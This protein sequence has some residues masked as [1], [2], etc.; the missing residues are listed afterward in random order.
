MTPA[1]RLILAALISFL[2]A[3]VTGWWVIPL[4]RRLKAGQ[5]IRSDGPRHH[6]TKA[7]TPTMGGIIFALPAAVAALALTPR[8]GGGRDLVPMLVALGTALGHGAVGFADDYIKVVFRRPLGL[9]AREKLFF[10][11][12]LA[13]AL[14]WAAVRLLGL[15]TWVWVPFVNRTFDLGVLYYPFVLFL[16]L[17]TG[18]AVNLTDG[19]DGLLGG[20]AVIV[21][22]F[23][24]Y[25]AAVQGQ[26]GLA[27]LSAGVAAGCLG[28]LR[29]NAHP[30]RVFM[31]DTGSL[32]LGGVLAALA[33][34]TKTEFLLPLSGLLFV[35]ETLSVILQVLAFRLTGRRIFRM[36]PL[37]HHFELGGW[38]ENEVVYRFWLVALAGVLLALWGL[39]TA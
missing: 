9:R 10:Q 25:L 33:V 37:H 5:T 12:F 26:L 20:A 30:A 27:V 17:A 4:L 35:L 2:L 24:T 38:S 36:S 18:N 22:T 14:A 15:G 1:M 13:L 34:L 39:G 7:G 32:F 23:Y 21:F 19:V 29:Y 28:F 16:V 31:G 11:T 8:E 6:L 3:L